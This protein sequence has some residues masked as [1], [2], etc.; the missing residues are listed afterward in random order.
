ML[1]LLWEIGYDVFTAPHHELFSGIMKNVLSFFMVFEFV[2]MLI[3]YIQEGHH[4][5]IR[6]IVLIAMTAILRELL[7]IQHDG[8]QALLLSLSC[9]LLGVML[10][11]QS[12]FKF[13]EQKSNDTKNESTFDEQ[14]TRD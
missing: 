8:V 4:I 1:R 2:V 12:T 11:L 13:H 7:V 10:M 14:N 3:R 9:L 5:P 6:Y